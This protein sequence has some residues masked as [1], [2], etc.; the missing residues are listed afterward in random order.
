MNFTDS[1]NMPDVA[2]YGGYFYRLA[3]P[4]QRHVADQ[5]REIGLK[6]GDVIVGREGGG[7]PETGWWQE[8][9]LT[10]RYIGEQC[11]VWKSEWS[12]KANPEFR[13]DGESANW[14]LSCRDWYLVRP[15]A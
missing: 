15:N 9:R 4:L 14:T 12:N 11:C 2:A 6:V 8:Q 13:D 10:L 3:R 5:V 7:D 1:N